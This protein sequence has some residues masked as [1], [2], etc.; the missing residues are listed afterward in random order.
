MA[1]D[2]VTNSVTDCLVTHQWFIELHFTAKRRK[3]FSNIFAPVKT[4]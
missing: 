4:S 3:N 1:S 2:S